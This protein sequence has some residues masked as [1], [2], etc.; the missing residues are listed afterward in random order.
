MYKNIVTNPRSRAFSVLLLVTTV[1]GRALS[2]LSFYK[3]LCHFKA[4]L[5]LSIILLLPPPTSKAYPIAISLHDQCAIYA[6]PPT[7]PCLCHTPYNIGD[8]NIV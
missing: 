8:G 2:L 4:L 7:P 1:H 5:W 6:R 3:I